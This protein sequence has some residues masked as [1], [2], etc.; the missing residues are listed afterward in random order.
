MPDDDLLIGLKAIAGYFRVE[1]RTVQRWRNERGLPVRE[2]AGGRL[3]ASRR[4]LDEW[5]VRPIRSAY[6]SGNLVTALDAQGDIIWIGSLLG[7]LRAFSSEE[8]AWR[9]QVSQLPGQH[10]P[11]V[12][13]VGGFSDPAL[14][15]AISYFLPDGTVAWSVLAGPD[16]LDQTGRPFEK[17]WHFT[18]VIVSPNGTIW[19]SLA[20]HA[21]W[22]GCVLRIDGQGRATL[23]FANTGY[24]ERLCIVPQERGDL[25]VACGENNDY[26]QAFVALFSAAADPCCSIPGKRQVYRFANSPHGYPRK[27]VLFPRTELIEARGG[28]PY[29]HATVMRQYPGRIIVHVET[30]ER[31]SSFMY[32][33]SETL[34]PEYV[35]PTGNHEGQHRQLE[36]AGRIDHAWLDC[37]ERASPLLLRV[38]ELDTGWREEM[39]RWRDDPWR[40]D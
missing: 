27:Y 3:A 19:A 9:I 34:V 2:L 5:Q 13:V 30:G 20:N 11:G 16:L 23:Q 21:G 17:A 10:K 39:I 26:D 36:E 6:A 35:F 31:G 38:W 28:H 29:G 7:A 4:E 15:D 22:A 1:P 32:H 24:V 18:H 14:P 37:P 33:F 12:L 25:V 40:D 8:L